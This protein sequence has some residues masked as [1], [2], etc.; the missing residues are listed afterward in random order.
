[1]LQIPTLGTARLRYEELFGHLKKVANCGRAT[2]TQ[3]MDKPIL[4]AFELAVNNFDEKLELSRKNSFTEKQT[5]ADEEFDA[6]YTHAFEYARVMPYFPVPAGAEAAAKILAIF[7]KYGNITRLGYTEEYAKGHN[8][9]QDI[10][11]LGEAALTAANFTPWFET[12]TLKHAQFTVLRENKQAEDT[13]TITGAAKEARKAAEEAYDIFVKKI[14]AMCVVMGEEHYAT[15]INQVITYVEEMQTLLKARTT[16]NAN[17]KAKEEAE[18]G[19]TAEGE[20]T[21]KVES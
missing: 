4:D 12:L 17:A 19:E 2:L 11:A 20:T 13:A 10:E 7:E 9:L 16:R 21:E 5:L 14:N 8:L 18:G 1:M 6:V 15:F 3:E